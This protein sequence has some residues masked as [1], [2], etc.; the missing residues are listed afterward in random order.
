MTSVEGFAANTFLT[1]KGELPFLNLI[2]RT[3]ELEA[4]GFGPLAVVLYD[5]W[6]QHSASPYRRHP[7]FVDSVRVIP[8]HRDP[9]VDINHGLGEDLL[10]NPRSQSAFQNDSFHNS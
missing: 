4:A 2:S 8:I 9:T 3:A 6:L 10:G 1:Y 7:T 5:T